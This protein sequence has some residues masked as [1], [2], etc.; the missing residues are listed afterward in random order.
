MV[1]QALASTSLIASVH[2][3]YPKIYGKSVDLLAPV[4]EAMSANI[5]SMAED[6]P[7]IWARAHQLSLY[8]V[9]IQL[10]RV[11]LPNQRT[12]V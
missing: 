6:A 12:L 11:L 3:S 4:P 8:L 7:K 9:L 5:V 1:F 10:A 2:T